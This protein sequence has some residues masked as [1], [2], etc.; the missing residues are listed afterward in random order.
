[1]YAVV[2]KSIDH[3]GNEE[4]KKKWLPKIINMDVIGCFGMTE[5]MHGSDVNS[6]ESTVKQV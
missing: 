5:I 2:G 4:Q 6:I 3:L 1:M